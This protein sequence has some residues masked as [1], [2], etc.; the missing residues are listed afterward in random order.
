LGQTG[1]KA[2]QTKIRIH[3]ENKSLRGTC[4]VLREE[5]EG[6]DF[7]EDVSRERDERALRVP[8][9]QQVVNT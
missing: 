8:S 1:A 6:D 5:A 4:D 3:L 9:A 2:D 7:R